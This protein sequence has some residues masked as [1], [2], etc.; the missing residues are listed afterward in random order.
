MKKTNILKSLLFSTETTILMEAHNA[1]SAKLAEEAGFRALWASGLS[2]S[3]SLGVRDNNEASWTQLLEIIEFMSDAT[4]IP[5]LFDGDTGFGNFNNVSRLVKKLEQRDIAGV[6]LEDKLFPKTNS[7]V[8]SKKQELIS[9]DEFCGKIRAAKD[10][11]KDSEFVVVARTEACIVGRGVE[12]ALNRCSAYAENGADAVLCHSGLRSATEVLE[13]ASKWTFS[14]PIVV[15]PTKYPNVPLSELKKKGIHNFIFA[16]Q[17]L[18]TVVAA[19]R[20]N[21]KKLFESENLM[22]IETDI[23]PIDDIFRLQNVQELKEMECRY[24]GVAGK[25]K[26]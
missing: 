12:E 5:I 10:T 7:F 14:A 26:K 13:F 15:I 11:Q 6:C 21:L 9:T 8:D 1:L 3:A 18:R 16:N 24:L 17:S 25:D 22:S 2:I 4:N 23:A 19:L 20:Q